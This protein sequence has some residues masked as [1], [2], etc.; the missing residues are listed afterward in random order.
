MLKRNL[1]K[2]VLLTMLILSSLF[3]FSQ[4]RIIKA[5]GGTFDIDVYAIFSSDSA[6]VT[7]FINMVNP[8]QTIDLQSRGMTYYQDTY[9][10]VIW[11][12]AI[13]ET[14]EDYSILSHEMLHAVHY[15]LVWAGVPLSGDTEEVYGYEMQCLSLQIFNGI[16]KIKNGE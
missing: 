8:D 12:P 5:G 11:M 16:N 1:K 6:Y 9:P 15:V 7:R 2:Y 14:V 10:I 4:T 3:S 13:P